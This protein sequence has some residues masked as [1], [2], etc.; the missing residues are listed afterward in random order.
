MGHINFGGAINNDRKGL[1]QFKKISGPGS[2][3][4]WNHYKIKLDDAYIKS[5]RNYKAGAYPVFSRAFFS[6][7]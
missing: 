1:I 3:V 6:L 4:S 2:I 7:Q 5:L